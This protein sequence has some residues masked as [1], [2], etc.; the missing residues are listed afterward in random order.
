MLKTFVQLGLKKNLRGFFSSGA[1]TFQLKLLTGLAMHDQI[2]DGREMI[3][4][5]LVFNDTWLKDVYHVKSR[6][7]E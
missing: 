6:E 5:D 2:E 3:K 7:R 4:R 1:S